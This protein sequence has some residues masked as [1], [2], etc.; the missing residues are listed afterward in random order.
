LDRVV[1]DWLAFIA[2]PMIGAGWKPDEA[3]AHATIILAGFRG[4][5]LDL[6]ATRDRERLDRAVELWLEM[7]DSATPREIAS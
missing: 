7:L 1:G 5:L 2:Q 6:C 4:F 3:R